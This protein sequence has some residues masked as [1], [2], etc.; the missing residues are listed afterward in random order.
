MSDCGRASVFGGASGGGGGRGF[1]SWRLTVVLR[2]SCGC[3]TGGLHVRH[4][5]GGVRHGS[6]AGHPPSNTAP[7]VSY[8]A[9]MP[10]VW[11][12][13]AHRSFHEWCDEPARIT[14]GLK[15]LRKNSMEREIFVNARAAGAEAPT[16]LMDL[17]GPAKAVP[18]LQGPPHGV[19]PQPV[20]SL[21]FPASFG[22]AEQ[23][24]EKVRSEGAV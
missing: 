9:P 11:V 7:Y 14:Y 6:R 4:G 17:C 21:D 2:A 12:P 1:G 19:F 10:P 5:S 16:I 18:L 22:A 23:L 15:R 3:K 13:P 20:K 24:A 8:M